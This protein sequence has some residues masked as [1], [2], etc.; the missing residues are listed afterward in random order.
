MDC[1]CGSVLQLVA[2][3]PPTGLVAQP[4]LLSLPSDCVDC[5]RPAQMLCS[6]FDCAAGGEGRCEV[7]NVHAGPR[8]AVV[9]VDLLCRRLDTP[10]R[11]PTSQLQLATRIRLQA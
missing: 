11:P 8:I 1:R 3:Q 6:V 5:P 2:S 4:K 7:P 9:D 10:I